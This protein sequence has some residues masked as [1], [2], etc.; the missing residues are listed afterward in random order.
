[1]KIKNIGLAGKFSGVTVLCVGIILAAIALI[2]IYT[3]QRSQSQITENFI[4]KLTIAGEERTADIQT[5]IQEKATTLVLLMAKS[6]GF[7]MMSY[8]YDSV[9]KIAESGNLDSHVHYVA[10]YDAEGNLIAGSVRDGAS[11]I[12]KEDILVNDEILGRLEIGFD[13]SWLTSKVAELAAQTAAVTEDAQQ[14][15]KENIRLISVRIGMAS[16]LGIVIL[17]LAIFVIFRWIVVTPVKKAVNFAELISQGDLTAEISSDS[18]DEI[19][20][21]MKELNHMSINLRSTLDGVSQNSSMVSFMAKELSTSSDHMLAAAEEMHL[22]AN[23]VSAAS[24]MVSENIQ[25]VTGVAENMGAKADSIATTTDEMAES[26]NSVAASIEEMSVSI[27]EVARSCDQARQQSAQSQEKSKISS[28]RIAEL[29]MAAREI[30]KVVEMITDITDQT[31]LLA[32]NATIEAAR[33]G[34]AGK[35]FAVV[36]NEVKDLARQTAGATSDIVRQINDMQEKTT[37]VVSSMAE[38][39]TLSD[40]V[41]EVNTS[42][43]AAVEEQSVTVG[44]IARTIASTAE[45]SNEVSRLIRELSVTIDQ[46]VV[47]GMN[48]ASGNVVNVVGDIQKISDGIE[49][50]SIATIGNSSFAA[51]LSKSSLELRDNISLFD[52]IPPKFDIGGVKAAHLVWRTRMDGLLREGF[53]LSAEDI[54]SPR[55]CEFGRWLLSSEAQE[56][57]SEPAFKEIEKHHKDVHEHARAMVEFKSRGDDKE[58]EERRSLFE[59][60]F[61]QLFF[62]LDRLYSGH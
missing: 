44:E 52:L 33:A 34:E 15:E 3:A 55:E 29:D 8:D 26:V 6:A 24:G 60:S 9:E 27:E 20:L 21:L 16:L 7:S 51:Q 50:S 17:C 53:S 57:A 10:F 5:L 2:S 56:F 40:S 45:G 13:L 43:S 1:M 12:V 31:K 11:K 62:A 14:T 41:N 35:G 4:G 28:E 42:I 23:S 32:L 61:K 38:I 58:A 49:K 25:E 46:D 30:G 18:N 47:S 59:E 39:S 36:A 19:G 22:K 37:V 48:D 54:P